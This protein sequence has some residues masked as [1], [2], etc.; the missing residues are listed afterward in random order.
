VVEN[1]GGSRVGSEEGFMR[2]VGKLSTKLQSFFI[3]IYILQNSPEEVRDIASKMIGQKLVTNYTGPEGRVCNSVLV[4][5]RKFSRREFYFAIVLDKNLNGPVLIASKHGGDN[6]EKISAGSPETV[7]REPL[8][9][10]QGMT[11]E[12]AAWIAR[13]VGICDQPEETIKMLRNLYRFFMQKDVL[14]AEVNPWIEDVC[15]NYYA[16]DAKLHFDPSAKF[17]QWEI[18]DKNDES[19]EDPKEAAARNLGV[20]YKQFNGSIGCLVNDPGLGL[21]TMDIL[22]CYGGKPANVMNIGNKAS[23]EV[24]QKSIEIVLMNPKVKTLFVNVFG[25]MNQCDV[26]ADGLVRAVRQLELKI[27]IVA[28]IQVS[29]IAILGTITKFF[30]FCFPGIKKQGS[31]RSH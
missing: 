17:R 13:R 18:F 21:A 8:D 15:M 14:I 16:M 5:E 6:F 24:V 19:Q 4:A 30:F 1:W 29:L 27:P 22:N 2:Q 26:A 20:T 31:S 28:R 11:E 10:C 9:I 7:I 12:M 3:N 23:A 25:G